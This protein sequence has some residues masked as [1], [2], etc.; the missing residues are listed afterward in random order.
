VKAS[1]DPV[2][3]DENSDA[4]NDDTLPFEGPGWFVIDHPTKDSVSHYQLK[5]VDTEVEDVCDNIDDIQTEVPPGMELAENGT[6]CVDIDDEC[7]ERISGGGFSVGVDEECPEEDLEVEVSGTPD[8]QVCEASGDDSVGTYVQG[9]IQLTISDLAGVERIDYSKDGGSTTEV[10]IHGSL[11][12]TNLAPGKYDFFVTV[13]D[14]YEEVDDFS[15]TVKADNDPECKKQTI[16]HWNEGGQGED[17]SYNEQDVSIQSIIN[18]PNGHEYHENDIIPPF[19]YYDDEDNLV[20]FPGL[21]YDPEAEGCGDPELPTEGPVI[22]EVLFTAGSCE[23]NGSY[24]LIS[25][26]ES[27]DVPANTVTWYVND[28]ETAAGTYPLQAG[29]VVTVKVVANFVDYPLDIEGSILTEHTYDAY[30]FAVPSDCDLMTLALTGSSDT[31]PALALTAFLGLLGLAMVRS[32]IRVNRS[33][34]EA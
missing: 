1:T 14:D 23:A 24:T 28:I 3:V 7:T 34:Q 26:A 21:N 13:A 31:T 12:I 33:R 19:D 27:E 5:L 9:S 20:S 2:I 10:D 15:V 6:S 17:G 30:S 11:L 22:P 25:P 29:E 18:V 4:P 32:G 8:H 16:C